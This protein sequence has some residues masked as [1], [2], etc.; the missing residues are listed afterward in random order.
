[1]LLPKRWIVER[2]FA[3]LA[4]YRRVSKDYESLTQTSEAMVPGGHDPPHDPSAGS[5]ANFLDTLLRLAGT[6]SL[7]PLPRFSILG[8]HLRE[9]GACNRQYPCRRGLPCSQCR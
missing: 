3:W 9:F 4:R 6:F 1:L 8:S 2:T 5:H 7:T